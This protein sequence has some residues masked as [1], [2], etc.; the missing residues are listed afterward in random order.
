MLPSKSRVE[1]GRHFCVSGH[2]LYRRVSLDSHPVTG[3]TN[4]SR[5]VYRGNGS[6]LVYGV[7]VFLSSYLV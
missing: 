6:C 4:D 7:R 3:C 2:M 5:P 1:G